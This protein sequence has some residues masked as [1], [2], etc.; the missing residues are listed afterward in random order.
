MAH[1]SGTAF[2]V[3]DDGSTHP[4]LLVTS[5]ITK[6]AIITLT[7][8]QIKALPTNGIE[9]VPAPG[10]NKILLLLGGYFVLR[11]FGSYTNIANASW[12]FGFNNNKFWSGTTLVQT[13]LGGNSNIYIAQI[14]GPALQTGTGDFSG[15]VVVSGG[16]TNQTD[17]NTPLILRDTYDGVSDYTGGNAGNTLKVTVYYI[18]VDL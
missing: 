10:E 2:V 12:T 14:S 3:E 15:E 9:I 11:S 17:A 18:I 16:V 5:P 6:T 7:D 4:L 8:A 1:L 13:I